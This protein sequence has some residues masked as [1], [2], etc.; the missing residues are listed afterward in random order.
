[1]NV[2]CKYFIKL[3]PLV[4][5]ARDEELLINIEVTANSIVRKY[6]SKDHR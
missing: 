5:N 6:A 3:L 4:L 1:M 2:A